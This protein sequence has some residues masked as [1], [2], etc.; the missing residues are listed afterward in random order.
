MA[1]FKGFTKEIVIYNMDRIKQYLLLSGLLLALLTVFVNISPT[2]Q[3]VIFGIIIFLTGVP[4]GSLDYFVEKQILEQAHKQISM[5][6]FLVKY[7]LNMVLYAGV[8]YVFPTVALLIFIGLTAYHFGEIDWPMRQQSQLEKVCYTLYGLLF[9]IFIISI[10]I[11]FA[12]PI[13]FEVVQQKISAATWLYWGNEIFFYNLL[14]L[15]IQLVF[16]IIFYKKLGWSKAIIIQFCVQTIVLMVIIYTLPLYIGFGFYFGAWH[17][18]LSFNLI[19]KQMNLANSLVGWL[20]LIKKALPFTI[21]AWLGIIALLFFQ[22]HFQT[23]WLAI[24]NLFVGIAI[25]TLPHLQV[26]T[27][28]KLR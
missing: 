3:L 13:L 18:I 21:V 4:H 5:A 14:A 6:T 1:I 26:F 9:I 20:S 7:F 12:A 15:V 10:H 23:E 22:T 19:R 25:L 27:K 11:D 24:S 8:W 17:S 28:I 2:I 16:L